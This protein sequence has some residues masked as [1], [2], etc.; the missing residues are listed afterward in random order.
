MLFKKILVLVLVSVFLFGD[1]DG[2]F[3]QL[4]NGATNIVK[5]E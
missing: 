2:Y 3:A 1:D 4:V 5:T